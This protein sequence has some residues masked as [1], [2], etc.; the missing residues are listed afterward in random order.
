MARLRGGRKG[1]LLALLLLACV[2]CASATIAY[3]LEKR[4]PSLLAARPPLCSCHAAPRRRPAW[5]G[6][7]CKRLTVRVS[8]VRAPGRPW[9]LCVPTPRPLRDAPPGQ[10]DNQQCRRRRGAPG[11]VEAKSCGLPRPLNWPPNSA[12]PGRRRT[13]S[14]TLL[15]LYPMSQPRGPFPQPRRASLAAQP[16]VAHR[17]PPTLAYGQRPRPRRA[18][19]SPRRRW[20]VHARRAA[21]GVLLSL[22]YWRAAPAAAAASRMH[23]PHG[24]APTTRRV[25]PLSPNRPPGS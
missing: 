22:D 19:P 24:P 14:P 12:G 21:L 20:T 8:R 25:D 1:V 13:R 9:K 4:A 3:D 23:P 11:P 17:H 10:A 2:Q 15:I 18:C 6:R 7:P 5:F 16:W